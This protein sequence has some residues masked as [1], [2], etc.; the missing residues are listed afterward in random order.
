L[1]LAETPRETLKRWEKIKQA[2]SRAVVSAGG[3]ISHQ[4]GVGLDHRPYLASEKGSLGISTLQQLLLHLDP[5]R[6]MNPT[7]LLP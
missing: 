1:R 7:K 4:H 6:R 5:D 3:T 2:A